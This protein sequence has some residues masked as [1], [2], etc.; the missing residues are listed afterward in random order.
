MLILLQC[1]GVVLSPSL[2]PILFLFCL[3]AHSL[4][5]PCLPTSIL[6]PPL[7]P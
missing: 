2:P 7:S 3:S 1:Y 6:P 5:L 4:T